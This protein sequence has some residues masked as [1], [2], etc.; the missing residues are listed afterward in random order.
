[1]N[2]QHR[3]PNHDCRTTTSLLYGA[4]AEGRLEEFLPPAARSVDAGAC[5]AEE[6]SEHV[7]SCE[8]CRREVESLLE[9]ER[10]I[11][12]GFRHLE[13]R[14]TLPSEDEFV[15][16]LR[17]IESRPAAD[18][19]RRIRRTLRPI[20]WITFFLLSLLAFSAL[21]IAAYKALIAK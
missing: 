7:A 6:M 4:W 1:M 12:G 11:A 19:I 3:D 2:P 16:M 13:R 10:A 5:G 18:W 20:A 8:T 14:T 15:R 9:M 17:R 21:V